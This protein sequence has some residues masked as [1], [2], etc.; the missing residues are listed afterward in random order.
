MDI[1]LYFWGRQTFSLEIIH[2]TQSCPSR[3]I[4]VKSA[5]R[6]GG[7][8]RTSSRHTFVKPCPG[9]ARTS[10]LTRMFNG[11]SKNALLSVKSM[12]VNTCICRYNV[13]IYTHVRKHCIYVW[14]RSRFEHERVSMYVHVQY[15]CRKGICFPAYQTQSNICAYKHHMC[16]CVYI[17]KLYIYIL[18][19]TLAN[20]HIHRWVHA[21][22]GKGC[23]CTESFETSFILYLYIVIK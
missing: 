13:Y 2:P 21:S 8:Q 23:F 16:V 18:V 6:Q 12:Y 11:K 14:D 5:Y 15:L 1:G 17:C 4:P 3:H 19:C 10:L 9:N 7:H 20:T 22:C